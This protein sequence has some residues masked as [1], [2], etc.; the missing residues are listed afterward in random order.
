VERTTK[1][2]LSLKVYWFLG[3]CN[4]L[5]LRKSSFRYADMLSN[6]LRRS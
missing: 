2:M 4:Y 3:D 6:G 1:G 5:L